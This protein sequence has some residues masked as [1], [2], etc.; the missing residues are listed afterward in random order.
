LGRENVKL[1]QT[2]PA[3]PGA[4]LPWLAVGAFVAG[5]AAVYTQLTP[6]A[7][8]L[9]GLM[10]LERGNRLGTG[11]AKC[12]ATAKLIEEAARSKGAEIGLETVTE[13]AAIV[14]MGVPSTPRA[15]I[16]GKVVHSGDLPDRAAVEKRL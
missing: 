16:D 11:C 3:T 15:A 13:I 12:E 1:Q 8:T 9:F 14:G 6:I 10:P 7:D 4:F 2:L 5:W